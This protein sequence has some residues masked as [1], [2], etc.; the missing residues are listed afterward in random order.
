M[1][2]IS[3]ENNLNYGGIYSLFFC[4]S[5]M[6]EYK[7]YI[8]MI[9]KIEGKYKNIKFFSIDVD[10]FKSLCLRFNVKS[11]PTLIIFNDAEE[12]KRIIGLT[13]TSAF[14][15]AFAD[16]YNLYILNSGDKNG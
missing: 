13:L 10:I 9:N 8:L 4:S 12:V 2:T 11:V 3:N 14:K 7:K 1:I 5:W 6:P 16:I 15:S